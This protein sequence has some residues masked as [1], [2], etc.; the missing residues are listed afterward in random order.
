MAFVITKL[1]R[2]KPA[3]I[4]RYVLSVKLCLYFIKIR[5]FEFMALVFSINAFELYP[6]WTILNEHDYDNM[7]LRN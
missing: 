5:I 6:C 1:S 2:D 3:P 7:L 4:F